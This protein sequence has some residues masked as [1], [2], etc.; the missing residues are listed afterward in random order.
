MRSS[1]LV[2][3][4]AIPAYYISLQVRR[5]DVQTFLS[6][7]RARGL[8]LPTFLPGLRA[9][10]LVG[11]QLISFCLLTEALRWSVVTFSLRGRLVPGCVN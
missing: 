10:G 6:G 11:P 4:W 9:R 7:L 1:L 3:L 5:L 8:A 2:V